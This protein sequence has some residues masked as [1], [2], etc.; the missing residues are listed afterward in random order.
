MET[1]MSSMPDQIVRR[2]RAR[3]R[4]AVFTPKDFLDLGARAAIDQALSRLV[5]KG[6]V[7]RL[8]R[9]LYDYPRISPKLGSLSPAPDAVAHAVAK[10]TGSAVQVAGAQ[11]A[12]LL[13]LS[14]QVPAQ[15][16]YLT[17]GPSRRVRIGRRVIDLR[18]A[19]PRSLVA[20]GSTAGTVIQA[21]R[22]VGHDAA[23]DAADALATTLSADDRRRLAR[24]IINAPGWMRP[25]L[26]RIVGT[27][28]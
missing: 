22:H 2:L 23:M 7:R 10:Q 19:S 24:E 6:T 8:T 11:A 26:G 13:G 20:P 15:S 4:G 1:L 12:N 3:G 21:L 18:H 27:V 25:I 17:D 28:V 5:R 14:T 9:G 16:T